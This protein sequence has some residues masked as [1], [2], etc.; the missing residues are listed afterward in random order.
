LRFSCQ[1]QRH[2]ERLRR[3][4]L[5]SRRSK[6]LDHW[7]SHAH[8]ARSVGARPLGQYSVDGT[9]TYTFNSADAAKS[10]QIRYIKLT[11]TTSPLAQYG[12]TLFDGSQVAAGVISP[13][14][15]RGRTWYIR[16]GARSRTQR[17]TAARAASFPTS[18]L[19]SQA[20]CSIP[21]SSTPTRRTSSTSFSPTRCSESLSVCE[22]RRAHAVL[23]WC[24]ANGLFLS[25]TYDA[26][27]PAAECIQELAISPMPRLSI[28]KAS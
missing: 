8:G 1:P 22:S 20:C 11:G 18:I 19:K 24:V 13:R 6:R 14:S 25:P 21:A 4:Y 10:I 17:L 28:L 9:G 26:Q 7:R 23:N 3:R 16:F 12:F 15:T 2:C 5:Q 27:R